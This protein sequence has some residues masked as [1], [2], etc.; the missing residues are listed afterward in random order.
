MLSLNFVDRCRKYFELTTP[1]SVHFYSY[2]ILVHEA[3]F[4]EQRNSLERDF[5]FVHRNFLPLGIHHEPSD[6]S[7]R[8]SR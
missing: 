5:E 1:Y 2:K 6:L 8:F 7:L 3:S 4:C